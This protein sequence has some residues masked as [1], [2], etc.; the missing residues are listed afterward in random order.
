[1]TRL[2]TWQY[3]TDLTKRRK[4][5]ELFEKEKKKKKRTEI[6]LHV[7]QFTFKTNF[8]IILQNRA[9]LKHPK[10]L[11]FQQCGLRTNKM[12]IEYK[13]LKLE[14]GRNIKNEKNIFELHSIFKLGR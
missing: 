2:Y 12:T 4:P 10:V 9:S 1:M 13:F 7:E 11:Q 3:F 8:Q 6:K 5:R 14:I